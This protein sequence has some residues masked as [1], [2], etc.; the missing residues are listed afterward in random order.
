VEDVTEECGRL[1]RE[2]LHDLHSSPNVVW[3]IKSRRMKWSGACFTNGERYI[4]GLMWKFDGRRPLG[5]LR[6][7]CKDNI[8]M[9]FSRTVLG[10]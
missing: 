10:T 3:V 7:G 4:Q 5:R 1:H 6:L 9:D 8:E 2:V